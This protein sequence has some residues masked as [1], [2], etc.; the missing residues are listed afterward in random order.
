MDLVMVIGFTK[1]I[2][3]SFFNFV[4][5]N[6]RGIDNDSKKVMKSTKLFYHLLIQMSQ[7]SRM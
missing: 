7:Q 6:Q 2:Q 5:S 3:L 1:H 4:T